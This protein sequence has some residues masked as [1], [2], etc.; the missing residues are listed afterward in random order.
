MGRAGC[1]ATES[2]GLGS[3]AITRGPGAAP[4]IWG[5]ASPGETDKFEAR[6]LPEATRLDLETSGMFGVSASAPEAAPERA[7]SGA[8]SVAGGPGSST[9]QRRIAP[10]HRGAVQGFFT[11]T[12]EAKDE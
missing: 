2:E 3:G 11:R 6:A 10:R 8:G 12:N 9:W 1:A 7:A 5:D 4:M